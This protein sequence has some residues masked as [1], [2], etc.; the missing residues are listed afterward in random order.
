MWHFFM[1]G[2]FL[3]LTHSLLFV[4]KKRGKNKKRILCLMDFNFLSMERHKEIPMGWFIIPKMMFGISPP[5]ILSI[6]TKEKHHTNFSGFITNH[7]DLDKEIGSFCLIL[8]WLVIRG[9]LLLMLFR[10]R[11]GL[12]LLERERIV[13]L[14]RLVNMQTDL[15]C[16]VVIPVQINFLP[17]NW[18]LLNVRDVEKEPIVQ[19][20]G[21]DVIFLNVLSGMQRGMLCLI[22]HHYKNI[23]FLKM[24]TFDMNFRFAT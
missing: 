19:L 8:L 23:S 14:V 12:F 10:V 15:G 6:Q 21:Q 3:S 11:E 1:R 5:L 22:Y 17:I 7:S 4:R 20:I 18:E 13:N 16:R 9:A 2:Q 24:S